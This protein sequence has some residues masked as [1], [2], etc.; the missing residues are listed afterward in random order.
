MGD[1]KNSRLRQLP[2][3]NRI[4]SLIAESGFPAERLSVLKKCIQVVLDRE[5]S[6]ETDAI[7]LCER[8]IVL[9]VLKEFAN[10]SRSP[11]MPVINATGVV[12][13]TGLGR[14][15]LSQRA[16]DAVAIAANGNSAVEYDFESGGRGDRQLETRRRLVTVTGAESSFV[17]NNNAAAVLLAVAGLSAGKEVIISRSELIEIG[18]SFRIP[19][20]IQLSG[21]RLVEVGSTNRT[22]LNDYRR[23]ITDNTGMILRCHASNFRMEGY[24]EEASSKDLAALASEHDIP[25]VDDLGSGS[26]VPMEQFGLGSITTFQQ[27]LKAG[28]HVVTGSGDKL[29]GGPQCGIILGATQYIDRLGHH[30]FARA[31]RIDKLSLAALNGTLDDYLSGSMGWKNI[32]TLRYLSRNRDELKA[33]AE[34]L[35]NQLSVCI[36]DGIEVNLMDSLSEIGAGSLPKEK[37]ETVCI[38]VRLAS[39]EMLMDLAL[40]L[41]NCRPAIIGRISEGVFL[42]DPRTLELSDFPIIVA[43]MVDAIEMLAR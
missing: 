35:R 12:L 36:N 14:A 15:S 23:A 40:R 7:I 3:V 28:A 6:R 30:P 32:P 29:F 21:A 16:Q 13:H 20:I 25:F 19:D 43:K 38:T 17:V 31:S 33:L 2:S 24:T 18:G 8:E 5:R 37:L 11:V 10:Q 1:L 42:L 22:R 26:V 39:N 41:R 34:D 4:T 9:T 27:S